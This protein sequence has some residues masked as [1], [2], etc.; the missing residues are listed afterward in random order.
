MIGYN[1]LD[2]GHN[3]VNWR[4]VGAGAVSGCFTRF[5]CQPFDVI[6]IRFQLQ[7]EPI[8]R[9]SMVSKYRSIPQ[10]VR[11]IVAEE[12]LTALWK[13]HL[14]AQLLSCVYGMIQFSSFEL[15]TQMVTSPGISGK[16]RDFAV[17]HQHLVHFLCGSMSGFSATLVAHPFD[18]IRTRIIAQSEPRTYTSTMNAYST[19]VRVEGYRGLF[20][21]LLPTLMQIAPFTGIQFTVY[22]LTNNLWDRYEERH[23]NLFQNQ[24]NKMKNIMYFEKT[25]LCGAMSGLAAKFMVYPLDLIK[26]RLQVEGFQAS[27]K[28]FGAI[29]SY[30]GTVDCVFKIMRRENF[31]A[32]YKGLSPSL[33]KAAVTTALNFSVYENVYNF[34]SSK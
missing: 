26:K 13:A 11:T 28:G 16:Q 8:N 19:I 29:D 34:L 14:C 33:M 9:K 32:F 1:P 12:G 2:K 10:T 24:S 22:N 20:R 25:F 15:Y 23:Q 17:K 3:G 30:K 4:H 27:R 6:K 7:L 31:L 18:V 21:G 5:L